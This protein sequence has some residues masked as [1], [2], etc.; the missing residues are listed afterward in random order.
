MYHM[1]LRPSFLWKMVPYIITSLFTLLDIMGLGV[2]VPTMS[3]IR[4]R[5]PLSEVDKEGTVANSLS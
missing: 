5:P 4:P 2:G 3:M 1:D